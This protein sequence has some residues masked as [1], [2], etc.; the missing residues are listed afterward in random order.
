MSLFR[1]TLCLLVLGSC[2]RAP[3]VDPRF[4][5][6]KAAFQKKLALLPIIEKTLQAAPP[7]HQDTLRPNT[8]GRFALI[9]AQQL[10]NLGACFGNDEAPVCDSL[11]W[12]LS[13]CKATSE[14]T[15]AAMAGALGADLDTQALERCSTLPLL[16]VARQTGFQKP[17]ADRESRSYHPGHLA[18]D[19][20]V[21]DFETGA[22]LG[23]MRTNV[24]TPTSL[25]KVTATTDVDRWLLEILGRQT[26]DHVA[27]HI[28]G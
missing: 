4:D 18:A 22:L 27:K 9:S 3:T 17:K 8:K 25:E 23:G 1:L 24:S 20:F 14:K 26:Y 16:A 5:P 13:A 21:F 10:T 12:S 19:V 11:W 6:A 7:L 28:D 15:A 2:R